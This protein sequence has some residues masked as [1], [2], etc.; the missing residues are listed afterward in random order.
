VCIAVIIAMA[1]CGPAGLHRLDKAGLRTSEPHTLAVSEVRSPA[2]TAEGPAKEGP[3]LRYMFGLLGAMMVKADENKANKRR[4]RWMKGCD[5]LDD[6][7]DE[8]R[9]TVADALAQH[10]TLEVVESDR[11]GDLILDIRTFK[12]GIHH[13]S[14]A[15]RD[16]VHFAV[17]YAGTMKLI[18]ARTQTVVAAARCSFEFRNGGDPPTINE[19]LEDDCDLLKKGLRLTAKSCAERYQTRA[20]GLD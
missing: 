4:T 19:L 11:G 8:I 13:I 18:D 16:A 20:L 17:A 10:F 3:D 7:V 14:A 1:G 2:I 6:P 12:W 5:E 9:E 15:S